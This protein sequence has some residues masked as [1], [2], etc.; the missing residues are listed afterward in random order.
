[1]KRFVLALLAGAA[2]GAA[3]AGLRF[4]DATA[5]SGLVMTT[6]S[7]R[8]LPTQ[9]LEAKGGCGLGLIDFDRDGDLDLFVPNGAY[10]DAPAAGPGARLFENLG[11]LRFRD[12]TARSGIDFHGW[13]MGVAVGDVDG[14]GFDDIFVAAYGP[15]LLL[16][17]QDG[18][19]FVDATAT[20]G[21]G[22]PRWGTAAAFGDFDADGDLDL[23]LA[24]YLEFDPARP[25]AP[26]R[27]FDQPVF[28]GPRGL[29]AAPD[30]LYENLGG[31][32]FRDVSAASGIAAARPSYGLGVAVL[33]FD[34]DGRSDVFVGNDSMPSFLWINQGG[35]RFAERALAAGLALN[36][37]GEAQAT[38]GIA[39][40][41]VNA[42]GRPD[43][44]TTNFA[45]DTNTLRVSLP[46][47][48]G[49]EDRTSQY[50]L[51][52]GSRPFLGW[53]AALHDFDHD[54]DEDLVAFNGHVYPTATPETMDSAWRQTPLLYER[55][56]GRFARVTAERAGAWLA[57]AHVDRSAAFGDLDLDGDVD[58]VVGELS[59]PLRLL[60]NDGARGHHL[61]VELSDA[62]PGVGNRRG[63]GARVVARQ[64][65]R[66]RTRWIVSGGSFQSASAPW[67]HFGLP[68]SQAV[69]LEVTWPDG[70][71]QRLERVPVDRRQVVERPARGGG[72]LP[73][74]RERR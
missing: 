59:G 62:R 2:A 61:L 10:L 47:A 12:V 31:G 54:G 18:R 68:G 74:G 25:P 60:R 3:P 13:G 71:V 52:A 30:V 44:F 5:A 56:G 72:G 73:R 15:D 64:A 23:Y 11:G 1:M 26:R 34:G 9:I 14:N 40:G 70:F 45:N 66:A 38:M 67:A 57:E 32:R 16:L 41:D 29:P 42:D 48:V 65:G 24:Q 8:G 28:G 58:V 39:L 43:L 36:G 49:W 69:D 19:R 22:D 46:G 50:G 17:N 21:L 33:D 55:V 7:G 4:V 35:G 63:L 37:D 53:A 20:S 27:F 6:T 51:A